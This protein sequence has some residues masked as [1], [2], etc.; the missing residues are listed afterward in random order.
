MPVV[1]LRPLARFH[2]LEAT[3][4]THKHG[5]KHNPDL[6]THVDGEGHGEHTMRH[7]PHGEG[8]KYRPD[9]GEHEPDGSER[10]PHGEED[11]MQRAKNKGELR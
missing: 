8:E 11:E 2:V 3:Y 1:V 7:K 9:M 6:D 4:V 5:F 10:E